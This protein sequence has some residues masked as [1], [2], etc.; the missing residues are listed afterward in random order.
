MLPPSL[1][2]RRARARAHSRIDRL[3]ERRECLQRRVRPRAA[4]AGEVAVGGVEGLEHRIRH[5]A[6]AERVEGAAIPLGPGRLVPDLRPVAGRRL[7]QKRGRRRTTLGPP[8]SGS[9][10]AAGRQGDVAAPA[11]RRPGTAAR[12]PAAGCRDR[13]PAAPASAA[14]TGDTWPRSRSAGAGASGSSRSP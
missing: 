11:R 13:G 14:T 6:I 10:S 2:V 9:S 3:V 7:E 4:H 12:G 1:S 8:T 5:G